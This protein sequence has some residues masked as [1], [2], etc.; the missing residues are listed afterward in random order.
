MKDIE[1]II[2]TWFSSANIKFEKNGLY[3][4]VKVVNEIRGSAYKQTN[5]NAEKCTKA[6]IVWEFASS[7]ECRW[8]IDG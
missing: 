2:L 6:N 7:R 3:D 8:S 5:N 4:T 1:I